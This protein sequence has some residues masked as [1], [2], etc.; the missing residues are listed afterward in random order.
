MD[1]YVWHLILLCPIDKIYASILGGRNRVS[2]SD[3]VNLVTITLA[4]HP[5]I[6]ENVDEELIKTNHFYFNS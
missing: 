1:D 2:D 4:H 5:Y 6:L 3:G